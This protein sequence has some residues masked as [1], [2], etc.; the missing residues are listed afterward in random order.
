MN[1]VLVKYSPIL[2]SNNLKTP[3]SVSK[4]KLIVDVY[5]VVVGIISVIGAYLGWHIGREIDGKNNKTNTSNKQQ[6]EVTKPR[7]FYN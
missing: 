4:Q 6:E 2:R 7:E 3:T 5:V 1:F